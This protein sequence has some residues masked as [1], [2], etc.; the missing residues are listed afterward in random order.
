M[1]AALKPMSLICCTIARMK[2]GVGPDHVADAK[3]GGEEFRQRAK[4]EGDA[5]A[6]VQQGRFGAFRRGI[7]NEQLVGGVEENGDIPVRRPA[8]TVRDLQQAP[9]PLVRKNAARGIV[10]RNNVEEAHRLAQAFDAMLEHV[11]ANAVSVFGDRQ[12]GVAAAF[13]EVA[14]DV[15][16]RIGGDD[17][18]RL[19]QP[20]HSLEQARHA[21]GAD[22]DPVAIQNLSAQPAN[23]LPDQKPLDRFDAVG[24]S[25]R[26][27]VVEGRAVFRGVSNDR[28]RA[29]RR[30]V[31]AGSS[32]R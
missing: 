5:V 27:A 25:F 29:L 1:A 17:E 23:S 14:I 8:Q 30:S 32:V 12:D 13:E 26:V 2:D 9:P 20:G 6:V 18:S 31:A 24:R 15:V 7:V 28:L 19:K 10:D 21:A 4:L 11:D 16:L 22:D 3:A